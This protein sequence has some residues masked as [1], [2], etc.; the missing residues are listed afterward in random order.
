MNNMLKSN[1]Y[2][3][4]KISFSFI[5]VIVF[6][7]GVNNVVL[8]QADAN[9]LLWG[10][11][12]GN[13]QV[14]TGLGATDIRIV[15]ARV[16]QIFLGFLGII[17]VLLIMYAGWLWMSSQG[18]PQKIDQA[19]KTL[20]SAVVGM[21]II[22]MAF[23]IV[24]IILKLFLEG[25][26]G[27]GGGLGGSSPKV[28]PTGS[29]AIGNCIVE[30][31][32]PVPG[33]QDVP[34][35]VNII[36]TFKETMDPT[37]IRDGAGNIIPTSVSIFK[38]GT[39]PSVPANL[40]SDVKVSVTPDNKTFV[41]DPV[42]YLGSP[43][44]YIWYSVLLT[45][46][47][48]KAD[49]TGAFD[50]CFE[51]YFEWSFEVNNK[52]DLVP[53]QVKSVIPAPDNAKDTVSTVPA[54]PAQGK[55][56][57]V[58]PPNEYAAASYASVNW[59]GP[60]PG[61]PVTIT[62]DSD[63]Q[64][65]GNLIVTISADATKAQLSN[66]PVSLGSAIIEGGS[67]YFDN[68]FKLT[69]VN[70]PTDYFEAGN[71]WGVNGVSAEQQADYLIVGKTKYVFGV[72]VMTDIVLSKV[73]QN[74]ASVLALNT[75]VNVFPAYV[76]GNTF[77]DLQAK[78]AGISGN[79]IELS[80]NNI[81]ALNI[82]PMSGGVDVVENVTVNSREDEPRNVV[83]QIN[84][85]EA[86]NPMNISGDAVDLANYLKVKCISGPNCNVANPHLFACGGDLCVRGNFKVSNVYKTTEF[87]SDNECAINACGDSIYCLPA[88]SNIEVDV[89]AANLDGCVNCATKSPYS[90]CVAD[91]LGTHCHDLAAGIMY[92]LA[93]FSAGLP[94]GI[95]DAAGNSLDGDRSGDAEGPIEFYNENSTAP[96]GP[97]PAAGA[98]DSFRWSFFLNSKIN[99]DPPKIKK[100][101]SDHEHNDT[102]V[103]L[104]DPILIDF[105]IPMMSSTLTT[106]A[107]TSTSGTKHKK[108]NLW[109]LSGN[110]VGYWVSNIGFDDSPPDG[111][112]D[113][114]RAQI[115]HI[116][117]SEFIT[118]RTQAG[119][120][121]KS[122]Y[123]NC[124][125]PSW[126]S[127]C[128]GLPAEV[129]C[130]GEVPT[131]AETCP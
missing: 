18:E 117:F 10:N 89:R 122:I 128:L 98:G 33:Q 78:V 50:K 56:T 100:I 115:N 58:G 121:L 47:I 22:L 35:N 31:V 27:G 75:E 113:W 111:K 103:P 19:K 67:V 85:N 29:G 32:Y 120:G 93:D 71:S 15:I 131:A 94:N 66:G 116:K 16:I 12:A 77:V 72:D 105:D 63:C 60:L 96:A 119:S 57:V 26:S 123:Q 80:T 53:P 90:D 40:I 6:L 51:N 2:R 106:G 4:A 118:Y 52:V 83:I 46:D 23:G 20:L 74:I 88:D 5:L 130:C 24:S 45:D 43:S 49:G 110:G 21:I 11:Q 109:A 81:T 9:G 13:V 99:L 95:V 61:K 73:A 86:I 114:T 59:L 55:I 69:L 3:I 82:V 8:A 28:P 42:N 92:P 48:K 101:D 87:V 34:R 104:L 30:M 17:A 129:S 14:K 127:T 107:Y 39:D 124:F 102:N 112:E 36:V 62:M 7:F 65:S 25:T 125:I 1:K 79:S 38:R 68:F 108:I 76:P 91:A 54:L 70:Y 44:E 41:F 126:S 97:V 84:F 64:E 37:S